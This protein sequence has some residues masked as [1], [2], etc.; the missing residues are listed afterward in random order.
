MLCFRCSAIAL[1]WTSQKLI[2]EVKGDKVGCGGGRKKV[3]KKWGPQVFVR[4][5]DFESCVKAFGTK[6]RVW[7]KQELTALVR[8]FRKR[9][10]INSVNKTKLTGSGRGVRSRVL[11]VSVHVSAYS[12]AVVSKVQGLR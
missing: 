12:G 9:N 4:S 8:P 11:A 3:Q 7:G 6:G 5:R 10:K 1:T 2:E